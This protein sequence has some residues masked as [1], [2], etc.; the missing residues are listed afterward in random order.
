M[1]SPIEISNLALSRI[2]IDQLIESFNDPNNRAKQCLQHYDHCREEALQDFPWNFAQRVVPL[3]LVA[4]VTVPGYQYVYRYPV[5]ALKV[6]GLTT[7][8]GGRVLTN[9]LA[10]YMGEDCREALPESLRYPFRVMADPVTVGARIIVTDL[11][12]A[13]LWYTDNVADVNQMTPLFRS[14]LAW[15]MASEIALGLRAETRLHT[16]AVQQYAWVVSQAQAHSHGET[17]PD[18]EPTPAAIAARY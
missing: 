9:R 6:H 10:Y 4:G 1:A 8:A 12:L 7:D 13:Y 17:A 16:N 2:G 3:A 15:K 14:A 18:P 11:D 5:T